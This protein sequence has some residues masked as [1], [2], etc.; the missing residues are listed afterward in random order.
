[1]MCK[2]TLQMMDSDVE[3]AEVEVQLLE[4]PL[5]S[6]SDATR[7]GSVVSED[8]A[9][10]ETSGDSEHGEAFFRPAV[11][12]LQKIALYETNSRLY[13]VGSNHTQSSFKVIK[14]DRQDPRSL[15]ISDDKTIYTNRSGRR[16]SW[17][18]SQLLGKI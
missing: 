11:K 12:T 10:S 2:S 9:E 14:I 6:V 13:L 8:S 1:M 5:A 15:L 4:D 7:E 18:N 17:L 16:S 3:D